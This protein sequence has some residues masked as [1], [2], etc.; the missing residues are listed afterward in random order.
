MNGR[1]GCAARVAPARAEQGSPW[2]AAGLV[3]LHAESVARC[4]SA[5][6]CAGIEVFASPMG[7]LAFECNIVA[8]TRGPSEVLE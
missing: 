7:G 2:P 6:G 5:P 1:M 8:I 4:F 3:I